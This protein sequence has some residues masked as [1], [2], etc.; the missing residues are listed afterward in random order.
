MQ[1]DNFGPRNL[2]DA[3]ICKGDPKKIEDERKSF[4]SGHTSCNTKLFLIYIYILFNK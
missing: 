3:S 1:I 2:F 4:P